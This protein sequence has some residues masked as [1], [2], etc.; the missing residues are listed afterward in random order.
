[1]TAWPWGNYEH[2]ETATRAW[3]FGCNEWCF[4]PEDESDAD[5]WE[6]CH[7]CREPLYVLRIAELEDAA[8]QQEARSAA[9]IERLIDALG[10]YHDEEEC[11]GPADLI[12]EVRNVVGA[13]NE[14]VACPMCEEGYPPH[15]CM[16][17]P[18]MVKAVRK[19]RERIAE[20]EAELAKFQP[21]D[22]ECLPNHYCS[23]WSDHHKEQVYHKEN[24]HE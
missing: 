17:Y 11:D 1:M 4:K 22:G 21:C 16:T 24:N 20:L 23:C 15:T 7:C 3:C 18:D 6:L 12:E 5:D 9:L 2:Q 13:L 19:D 8:Q 10:D 14:K